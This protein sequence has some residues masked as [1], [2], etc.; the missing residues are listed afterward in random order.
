MAFS[1]DVVSV[2]AV[3]HMPVLI[4][5]NTCENFPKIY[6]STK[7]ATGVTFPGEDGASKI[8]PVE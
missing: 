8:C 2:M 6:R 5:V 3:N 1:S 4:N 7:I